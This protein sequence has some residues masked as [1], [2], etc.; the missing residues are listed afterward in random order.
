MLSGGT[1][2]RSDQGLQ[3]RTEMVGQWRGG[4]GGVLGVKKIKT[5]DMKYSQ[6]EKVMK[7]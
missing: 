4:R 6:E 2:R 7:M 5:R 1:R 3:R